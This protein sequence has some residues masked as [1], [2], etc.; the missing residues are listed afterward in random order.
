MLQS[1][2]KIKPNG[3]HASNVPGSFGFVRW[4]PGTAF[5]C[6][7]CLCCL[8]FSSFQFNQRRCENAADARLYR[9]PVNTYSMQF[10]DSGEK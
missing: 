7:L 1:F 10:P 9:V 8:N 3:R 5:K 2:F 6:Q 4:P